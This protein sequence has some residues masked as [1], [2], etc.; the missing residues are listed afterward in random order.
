[1]TASRD[2][3]IRRKQIV[4]GIAVVWSNRQCFLIAG[5]RSIVLTAIVMNFPMPLIALAISPD[6]A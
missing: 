1:L 4:P 2:G 6:A 5:N 3:I